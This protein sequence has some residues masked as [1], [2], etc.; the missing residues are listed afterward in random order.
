MVF[1]SLGDSLAWGIPQPGGF[2]FR[3][4]RVSRAGGDQGNEILWAASTLH[5]RIVCPGWVVRF[6]PPKMAL[7]FQPKFVLGMKTD[8]SSVAQRG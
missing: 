5:G 6:I 7:E 2:E 8:S 4:A 3:G 1:A